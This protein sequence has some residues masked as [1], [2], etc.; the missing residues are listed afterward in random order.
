M[1]KVLEIKGMSAVIHKLAICGKVM[2]GRVA[3][4]L[5]QAGLFV[6]RESQKICPIDKGPL[7][8]GASKRNV[9]GTGIKTDIVV[10]YHEEYA[11]YVHENMNAAHNTGTTA[12][13]LERIIRE[14]RK[15]IM[16]IIKKTP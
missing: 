2:E 4:G 11:I 3:R 6:Q 12:K 10:A 8:G 14:R 1:A 15:E 13:Y 5:H 9:G 7:R 16:D